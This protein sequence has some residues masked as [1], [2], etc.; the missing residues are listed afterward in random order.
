MESSRLQRG[1]CKKYTDG[2]EKAKQK[3][4]DDHHNEL[5]KEHLSQMPRD[6]LVNLLTCLLPIV[7]LDAAENRYL[8]GAEVKKLVHKSDRVLVQTGGGFSEIGD[9]LNQYAIR[10][11]LV[12]WKAMTRHSLTF[13]EA[14]TGMLLQNKADKRV[15][16]A[17][18]EEVSDDMDSLFIIVVSL[19]RTKHARR[20]S[21]KQAL[22]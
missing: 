12:I 13:S 2:G 21:V 8:V 18:R 22:V 16:T 10:E 9:H 11:S 6:E 20:S 5:I 14:I 15:I 1:F 7:R 4:I 19:Y 3:E 17:F